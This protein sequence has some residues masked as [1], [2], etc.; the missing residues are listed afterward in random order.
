MEEYAK[1]ENEAV[2][3][4]QTEQERAEVME[5]PDESADKSRKMKKGD[6]E[7]RAKS[8]NEKPRDWS[9]RWLMKHGGINCN[10]RTSLGRE[11]STNG[12]L[13]SKS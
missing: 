13:H 5:E 11:A 1:G 7:E 12:F 6:E 2:Q 3:A 4:T 10:S 8:S 9:L